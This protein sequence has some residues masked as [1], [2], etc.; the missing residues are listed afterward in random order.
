ML[1]KCY[2]VKYLHYERIMINTDIC[3]TNYLHT[4]HVVTEASILCPTLQEHKQIS[5]LKYK[6]VVYNKC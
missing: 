2:L 5:F 4:T 1:N 3:I 6:I